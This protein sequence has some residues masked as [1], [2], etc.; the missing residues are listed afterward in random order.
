M[1]N[2][3]FCRFS[4]SLSVCFYH[5]LS[6]SLWFDSIHSTFLLYV[7]YLSIFWML[8]TC[9]H[10]SPVAQAIVHTPAVFHNGRNR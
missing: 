8:S 1:F 2:G 4:P 10:T 3:L 7:N 6:F 5:F 9:E